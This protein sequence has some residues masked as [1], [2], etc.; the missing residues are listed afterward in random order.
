MDGYI[1][2]TFG[3]L[4]APILEELYI[5]GDSE[6]CAR[7]IKY[8]PHLLRRFSSYDCRTEAPQ[9]LSFLKRHPNMELC[10]IE[11][12]EAHNNTVS[13]VPVNHA[14]LTTLSL[15]YQYGTNLDDVIVNIQTPNL[16]FLKLISE[17]YNEENRY[18]PLA[19]IL[20]WARL[21]TKPALHTLVFQ[22]HDQWGFPGDTRI[23]E[24]DNYRGIIASFPTL[25]TL[26][27]H[28]GMYGQRISPYSQP[29]RP[30]RYFAISPQPGL[31][32]HLYASRLSPRNFGISFSSFENCRTE[33]FVIERIKRRIHP[34]EENPREEWQRNPTD[35]VSDRYRDIGS[36][37]FPFY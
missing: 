18:D 33:Y 31:P 29:A 28:G 7:I 10:N 25:E 4:H 1:S 13:L 35:E 15:H 14:C 20:S 27:I 36:Y 6:C 23:I 24:R 2:G 19:S 8:T 34:M 22:L 11:L 17:E 37:L 3:E 16:K 12:G 21:P 30:S 9:A 26:R 5:M 32:W